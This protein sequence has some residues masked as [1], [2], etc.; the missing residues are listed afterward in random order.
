MGFAGVLS[1]LGLP[2]TQLVPSL[3]GFNIGV[4]LGQLMVVGLLYF[5]TLL[6]FK[7]ET[8]RKNITRIVAML[9]A[10]VAAFWCIERTL[11]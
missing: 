4:E 2:E 11:L 10:L 1:E 5:I 7:D 9:I 8:M 3:L 6:P